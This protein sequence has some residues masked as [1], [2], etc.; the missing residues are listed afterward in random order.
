MKTRMTPP[1][2]SSS[3][4]VIIHG[5]SSLRAFVNSASKG[6]IIEGLLSFSPQPTLPA[7]SEKEP[8]ISCTFCP[9]IGSIAVKGLPISQR[10]L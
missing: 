9:L 1:P 3:T 7:Q 5:G 6:S 2:S 4:L 8:V 10:I